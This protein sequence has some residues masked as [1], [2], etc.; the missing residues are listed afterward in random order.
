MAIHQCR[1]AT[2][3]VSDRLDRHISRSSSAWVRY[4]LRTSVRSETLRSSIDGITAAV[5]LDPPAFADIR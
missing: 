5:A 3:P 4:R 2:A 1:H